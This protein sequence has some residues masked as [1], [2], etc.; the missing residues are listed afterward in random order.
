MRCID[1]Q[2]LPLTTF[3]TITTKIVAPSREL[4]V[5]IAAECERLLQRMSI[6]SLALIG[7]AN[8]A[9]Q[10]EKLKSVKPHIVVGTPGRLLDFAR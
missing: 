2:S 10:L 3:V 8:P 9:R 1:L 7:G 4:G 5:Q 6:R